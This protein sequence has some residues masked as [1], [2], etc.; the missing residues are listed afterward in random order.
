MSE[1]QITLDWLLAHQTER[2]SYTYAQAKAVGTQINFNKGWLTALV[3]KKIT[4]E[5]KK[6]FE[7]AK[8]IFVKRRNPKRF[9][10]LNPDG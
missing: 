4:L 8:H 7:D 6:A 5:Q 2:G 9:G 10:S 3:G 1:F